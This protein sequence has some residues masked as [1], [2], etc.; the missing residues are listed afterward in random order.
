MQRSRFVGIC[1][2]GVWLTSSFAVEIVESECICICKLFSAVPNTLIL[3][4]FGF[5]NTKLQR[6]FL[7]FNW[8]LQCLHPALLKSER[9]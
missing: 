8:N 1:G 3:I 9:K 6:I 7:S 5:R 2:L 4:N